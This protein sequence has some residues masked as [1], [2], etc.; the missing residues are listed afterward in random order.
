MKESLNMIKQFM[1][2][3]Y[4]EII[5]GKSIINIQIEEKSEEE[6]EEE[7]KEKEGE[8]ELNMVE[9]I[10]HTSFQK[11]RIHWEYY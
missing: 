7:E 1:D 3:L 6:E 4:S 8:N 9:T 10:N 2:K 5:S 11:K